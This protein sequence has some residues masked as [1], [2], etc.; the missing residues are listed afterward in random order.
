MERNLLRKVFQDLNA[1]YALKEWQIDFVD[2][3]WSISKEAGL[4]NKTMQICKDELRHCQ[5]MSPKPNFLILSGDRY[6]WIP[7]PEIVPV[8]VYETLEMTSYEQHVF[9]GW[10]A[11]DE[12]HLPDG[13]YVLRSRCE[14]KHY[15]LDLFTLEST[16]V[17][18]TDD[19]VWKSQVVDCLS[20][21]FERNCCKLYGIS[22]TEQEI[23]LG[24]LSI[25][26][27]QDHVVAYIRHL[28][29]V[30]AEEKSV[31]LECDKKSKLE[32]LQKRIKQKLSD[33]NIVSVDLS[34]DEYVSP[35]YAARFRDEITVHLRQVI[36]QAIDEVGDVTDD[37]NQHHIEYALQESVDFV[38]REDELKYIKEYIEDKE[39]RCGLWY[40]AD[41]GM[42]KSA[43]LAKVVELYREEYDVICRFCGTTE[44]SSNAES[45]FASMYH[46]L[47]SKHVDRR[48]DDN[49]VSW[50]PFKKH[51][52]D[53][54][55]YV[56]SN[57]SFSRP[58]LLIIDSLDRVDDSNWREFS[59]LQWLNHGGRSDV[60]VII[61]STP[62][63]K[64]RIEQPFLRKLQLGNLDSD[65]LALIERILKKA[66]RRLC[67]RQMRQLSELIGKS[68]KSPLYLMI[69]GGILSGFDSAQELSGLPHTLDELVQH[70]CLKLA[71]PERHGYELV[72]HMVFW[73]ATSA[74]GVCESDI[75]ELLSFDEVYIDKL[76]ANSMHELEISDLGVVV[77]PIIWTRL[78]YD[79]DPLLRHDNRF[80]IQWITFFHPRIRQA[81][82]KMFDGMSQTT[83]YL[84]RLLYSYYQD[85]YPKRQALL[86]GPHY[87]F[88][89][90][91]RGLIT[92]QEFLHHMESN[93]DYLVYKKLYFH[94]LLLHDYERALSCTKDQDA[95][96]RLKQT[97]DRLHSING[98]TS[99]EDIR[100]FFRNMPISSPLRHAVEQ[101]AEASSYMVDTLSYAPSDESI[102]VLNDIGLSPVMSND[103]KVVAS[104][105]EN[106]FK[107][108]VV[109]LEDHDKDFSVTFSVQVRELQM[110]DYA[111]YIASRF[112]DKCL[113]LDLW[114]RSVRM[115][116]DLANGNWISLA[117]NGSSLLI[118]D[119]SCVIRR[120][121]IESSEL[122]RYRNMHHCR[123]SPSGRYIWFISKQD[124]GLCRYDLTTHKHITFTKLPHRR[125]DGYVPIQ[126]EEVRIV[127][128]S[129]ECCIAGNVFVM[130]YL[131]A[132]GKDM[133]AF[134]DITVAPHLPVQHPSMFVCRDVPM[135][136]D[137]E[138][139]CVYLDDNLKNHR[140]GNTV[141]DDLQCMNAD[142]TV[143]L[144]SQQGRIFNFLSEIKKFR[145]TKRDS[146]LNNTGCVLSVSN[147]ASE[148]A[149]SSYGGK[150]HTGDVNLL[151]LRASCGE[152][153][154]WSPYPEHERQYNS[155]PSNALS[156]DGKLLAVSVYCYNCI[157]CLVET[158]ANNILRRLSLPAEIS[159]GDNIGILK[160]TQDA[161][162][163][164]I[165]TGSYITPSNS[166]GPNVYVYDIR[167]DHFIEVVNNIDNYDEI[168]LEYN[169]AV[170]SSCNRY[171]CLDNT[172]FDVIGKN[173][174]AEAD[175][176]KAYGDKRYFDVLSPSTPDVY[177]RATNFNLVTHELRIVEENKYLMAISPSGLF[178]YYVEEGKLYMSRLNEFGKKI[179]LRDHVLEVYPA[180][181]D[182]YIYIL[183]S[184][185]HYVLYDTHA[186]EDLQVATKGI[187]AHTG[188]L[189]IKVCAKGLVV[190]NDDNS[191]LSLFEP[192]KKYSVNKPAFT[193]F[194]RRWDLVDKVRKEAT[195][196]CPMCGRQIDY[197][198]FL[199]CELKEYSP[200]HV[201]CS[202]WDDSKLKGHHCPH[203]AA[204][205]QFTPYII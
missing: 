145:S 106:S 142:F 23:Q 185:A 85:N 157:I 130:H 168:S 166:T 110:D 47:A 76:K 28:I 57:A 44:L 174:V 102:Y 136:I 103:G 71:S 121:D 188:R 118:G 194:V 91:S 73:L 18:Y 144:S 34:Y 97:K 189:G 158:A 138:A 107:I 6:G 37:E 61:S 172:I 24:A 183:D 36:E 66:N 77:P 30:P 62:E 81:V 26:G 94:S 123:I 10:Y 159:F 80:K 84:Y 164:A 191:M 9:N 51:R 146:L 186:H 112:E 187:V 178:Y 133:C 42:G 90:Y 120:F 56:L 115:T 134:Y 116:F 48:Y 46:D 163:L 126:E 117:A 54:F 45:L 125:Y 122:T 41:A 95:R 17:D 175:T 13:A 89:A 195:A 60:K 14:V 156:P 198:D 52:I 181:D 101:T 205:I 119:S 92:Q 98:Y 83:A 201:D 105:K 140:V 169:I 154:S 143:A 150:G 128:C 40:Q 192:D 124:Y 7:L 38:G 184:T 96:K 179:Y 177:A 64:Y 88:N 75:A 58:V 32:S 11:L 20:E 152:V 3:R 170:P 86:E 53:D 147:D 21:M 162:Y 199:F 176:D 50:T 43:L 203:C 72:S 8:D 127:S 100:M 65:A 82:L 108:H 171:L 39:S 25:D 173:V 161:E 12:N 93:L 180:L 70:Y 149:V 4:E 104:L 68:D 141:L 27:A 200:L 1:E 49:R 129:D 151:M 139:T 111:H 165:L 63:L 197:K 132:D 55:S 22:A 87:L 109:Y 202:D 135:W 137:A 99:A 19:K 29:D 79:L 167:R 15:D 78:R 33:S 69:L 204:E 160:F 113:L 193:S 182:R 59:T 131:D 114:S 148:I 5:Q 35:G 31:F 196:V 2:L 190:F 153:Y 155:L 67:D 16:L 74:Y